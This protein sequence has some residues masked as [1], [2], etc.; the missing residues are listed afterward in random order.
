MRI[1]ELQADLTSE[2]P[3]EFDV[4]VRVLGDRSLIPDDI[5]RIVLKLEK[6]TENNKSGLLNICF[7]YTSRDDITQAMVRVAKKVEAKELKVSDID[8]S[9]LEKEM[10][11]GEESLALD[12]L[13]RTSGATRFSDFMIWQSCENCQVEFVDTLWPAFTKKEMLKLLLKWGFNETRHL[14]A[15]ETMQTRRFVLAKKPF[16]PAAKPRAGA[17][18]VVKK[19]PMISVTEV[20]R[21]AAAAAGVGEIA[22]SAVAA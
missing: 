6:L 5:M 15:E 19:P 16:V 21:S 22:P 1:S 2:I 4:K 8:T 9:V 3:K 14:K 10:Y 18:E 13:V 11:T 7:P 12:L 20:E 17:A